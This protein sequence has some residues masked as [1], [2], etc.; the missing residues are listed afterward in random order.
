MFGLTT[1][2]VQ[3]ETSSFHPR[4]PYAIAKLL[5]HWAAINYR[6]SFGF[7]A[8]AGILFTHESPVG[9]SS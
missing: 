8:C 4:S 3:S 6:E 2:P 7:F 5:E 9:L 1:D